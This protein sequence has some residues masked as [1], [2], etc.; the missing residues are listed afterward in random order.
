MGTV[1]EKKKAKKEFS[2]PKTLKEIENEFSSATGSPIGESD[3]NPFKDR[4]SCYKF[5]DSYQPR[6]SSSK[7]KNIKDKDLASPLTQFR[8]KQFMRRKSH[9]A[10]VDMSTKLENLESALSKMMQQKHCQTENGS[11]QK[12]CKKKRK[13]AKQPSLFKMATDELSEESDNNSE[14]ANSENSIVSNWEDNSEE[15]KELEESFLKNE[16]NKRESLIN[17]E[18]LTEDKEKRVYKSIPTVKMRQIGKNKH[19]SPPST[20]RTKK[21]N[22]THRDKQTSNHNSN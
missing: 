2:F 7:L 4:K 12:V 5:K 10:F 20:R 8:N 15:K 9:S 21:T 13:E 19:K 17:K 22:S 16:E 14:K 3:E 6:W 11:K 18:R 1:A